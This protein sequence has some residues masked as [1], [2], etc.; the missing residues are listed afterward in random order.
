[1][2]PV[3]TDSCREMAESGADA[4]EIQS[5]SGHT[6]LKEVARYTT[7]YNRKQG[8]ARARAKVRTARAVS[9]PKAVGQ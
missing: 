7:A 3:A 5:V 2:R 1:V 4:F 9:L 6:T 8:A